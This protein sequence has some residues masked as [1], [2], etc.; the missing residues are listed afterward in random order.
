MA[1]KNEGA[2]KYRKE[3]KPDEIIGRLIPDPA[4]LSVTRLVGLY[5]GNSS[6]NEYWRL[7]TTATLNRYVE[8]RKVDALDSERLP[9]GEIV[10]WLKSDAKVEQTVTTGVPEEF[11]RGD[12]QG[13]VNRVSGIASVIRPMLALAEDRS[14][15][16]CESGDQTP[17]LHTTCSTSCP[18]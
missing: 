11:L 9:S 12:L 16:M 18:K 17:K 7:Y 14:C 1:D 10:V 15:V 3:L 5:L 8:F 2:D 4:N 6:R 13:S